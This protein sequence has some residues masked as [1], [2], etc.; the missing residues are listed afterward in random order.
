MT[1]TDTQMDPA[2]IVRSLRGDN[3]SSRKL[4]AFHLQNKVGDPDFADAF[5][6]DNGMPAL[7]GMVL[8][9][10]GNTLAY[11]LGS[12]NGILEQGIGWEDVGI[13]VAERVVD[14][15]VSRPV[16]NVLRNAFRLLVLI[17]TRSYD[18]EHI[19]GGS[20]IGPTL[21]MLKPILK[22]H[23]TF[24]DALI[25]RLT[26]ADHA[27]CANALQ[28]MNALIRDSINTFS[29]SQLMR[30]ITR[31]Q[32]LDVFSTVETLMRS[33]TVVDIAAP[34]LDFQN[35][36]KVMLRCWRDLAV[37]MN[38]PAHKDALENLRHAAGQTQSRDIAL[39]Q[40]R[41]MQQ[42]N[43]PDE[44]SAQGSHFTWSDLGFIS[45]DPAQD[46]YDTGLLGLMDLVD[47]VQKN[48]GFLR[49]TMLEQSVISADRR[50]P[51]ARA[52]LTVTL[53]LYEHFDIA[54][55]SSS[56]RSSR[57]LLDEQL[58]SGIEVAVH[59]LLLCRDKLHGSVVLAFFRLWDAAGA[60]VS[61]YDKIEQLIRL[62][63][64]RRV[65]G[66]ARQASTQEVENSIN[67]TTL[68]ELR[69]LQL[70]EM[71]RLQDR[72]WGSDLNRLRE[73]LHEESMQFM[74]EQRIR[75]LLGGAWFPLISSSSGGEAD[76][77]KS[78]PVAATGAT[79]RYA[80]L[81]PNRRYLH[82]ADYLSRPPEKPSLSAMTHRIDVN[83]ISSVVSNVTKGRT[84]DGPTSEKQHQRISEDGGSA[85]VTR[86]IINGGDAE[87]KALLELQCSDAVL[88]SEWLDGL[89]MLLDQQPITAD[90]DRLVST[91]ENWSLKVRLLNLRWEDADWQGIRQGEGQVCS[92]PE[93]HFPR[94]EFEG[95]YWYDMGEG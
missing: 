60:T 90:T 62:L 79:W 54:A 86:L 7:C 38:K 50:C 51:F 6:R 69:T 82:H 26:S 87:E 34:V 36:T 4:A 81:S 43:Q 33:D 84:S 39:S 85:T 65:G 44:K 20:D 18:P 63:V 17:V 57:I 28:F 22:E 46:L 93:L 71:D 37:D 91:M 11:G 16:I 83:H 72:V 48:A 68:S 24:L 55:S 67:R 47:F 80:Q 23:A 45:E 94:P 9:E 40:D 10:H 74:Q 30:F 53:I 27:L 66:A 78:V 61:E 3:E 77:V 58:H 19:I 15:V 12:L 8:H 1:A 29:E 42:L 2:S 31:L 92:G 75:C 21:D 73:R 25:E 35:L 5:V 59:P 64:A 70:E 95:E 32:D 52:C 41:N 14:L 88:A 13:D 56:P 89:L 76:S 49:K